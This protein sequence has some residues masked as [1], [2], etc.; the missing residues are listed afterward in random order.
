[1]RAECL[2]GRPH[3]GRGDG[4]IE[5]LHGKTSPEPPARRDARRV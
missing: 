2:Q 1:M 5:G 3:P 4:Q